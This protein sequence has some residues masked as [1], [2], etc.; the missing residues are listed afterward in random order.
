VE[1]ELLGERLG[2]IM[3]ETKPPGSVKQLP[4]DQQQVIVD[5]FAEYAR[6]I[7][8]DI[9]SEG[10]NEKGNIASIAGGLLHCFAVGHNGVKRYQPLW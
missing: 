4:Q 9:R 10:S 6:D 7:L 5:L 1:T 8:E 2:N 3:R